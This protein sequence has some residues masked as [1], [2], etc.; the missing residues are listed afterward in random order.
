MLAL[1]SDG[2]NPLA[3]LC[4][5]CA[6]ADEPVASIFG[7]DGVRQQLRQKIQVDETDLLP[8][9]LCGPCAARLDIS[10]ELVQKCSRGQREL[11]RRLEAAGVATLELKTGSKDC[12]DSDSNS[13]LGPTYATLEPVDPEGMEA[14]DCSASSSGWSGNLSVLVEAVERQSRLEPLPSASRATK[15]L[16]CEFC[17]KVF[18]HTGDL[19]K[20]RRHHTKEKPYHCEQCDKS[21]SHVSNLL[22][23]SKIHSGER[24]FK[25]DSCQRSFSR[26]D[27]LMSHT[28]SCSRRKSH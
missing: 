4:R 22:R 1:S 6:A 19:N 7:H 3:G 13:S 26:S 28:A 9:T 10:Y 23:H 24:P 16:V 15:E 11:R 18:H 20:H 2:A 25:C 17:N 8:N 27:K 21:F 5:V 12:E 14:M